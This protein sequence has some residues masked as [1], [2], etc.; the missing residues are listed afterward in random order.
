MKNI[1][2]GITFIFAMISATVITMVGEVENWWELTRPWVAVFVISVIAFMVIHNIDEIRRYTYPTFVVFLAWAYEHKLIAN[3]M[4]YHSNIMLKKHKSYSKLYSI[5]QNLYD[6][7][8]F[9]EV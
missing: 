7:L 1:L 3:K 6:Q 2:S 8:M 5:T 4:S 9:V